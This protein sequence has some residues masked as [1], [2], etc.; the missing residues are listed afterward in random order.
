LNI[1][2]VLTMAITYSS[3]DPYTVSS[4]TIVLLESFRNYS[5]DPS[6]LQNLSR[7]NMML[8]TYVKQTTTNWVTYGL[9]KIICDTS[10]C[11]CDVT[12]IGL[13]KRARYY[14]KL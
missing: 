13:A 7:D 10:F 12:I 11:N 9:N 6:G 5:L 8:L 2:V 14:H 3:R 1:R 4:D